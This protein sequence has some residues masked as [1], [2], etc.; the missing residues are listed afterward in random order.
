MVESEWLAGIRIIAAEFPVDCTHSMNGGPRRGA[1]EDVTSGTAAVTHGSVL[2]VGPAGTGMTALSAA[3]QDRGYEVLVAASTHDAAELLRARAVDCVL[4]PFGP[5]I[6]DECGALS[7]AGVSGRVPIL[8]T[9]EVDD[10]QLVVNALAAGADDCAPQTG[11]LQLFQARFDALVRRRRA[12]D[13][14]DRRAAECAAALARKEVELSS[15]NYAVSHDLRAPLRAIDGF[16]RILLEECRERFDARHAGY[17]DRISAA[18]NELGALIEDLL[19]LSRV[20]RAELHTSNVDLSEL[21]RRVASDLRSRSDRAVEVVVEDGVVAQGDRRLLR[22][23]LE[24]LIGNSWKFTASAPSP[25]IEC[26]GGRAGGQVEFCIV[27]NGVGFD[28]TRVEKLF[29]PFQRLHGRGEFPGTGIG[30][31]VAHK[32]IDRH[33]GRIRAEGEVGRGASFYFTLPSGAD[34]DTR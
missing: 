10:P 33:G 3:L 26:R 29:Q 19:Q 31:A 7:A 18:A 20:G 5:S 8:A 1:I 12:T 27:D 16:S 13:A 32:I 34:G 25:R 11:D 4:L 2:A 24:Q 30:L 14:V 17:L 23:V 15:L 21:A 22:I 6:R 9:T 28:G